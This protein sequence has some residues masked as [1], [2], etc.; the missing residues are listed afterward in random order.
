ML[1]KRRVVWVLLAVLLIAGAITALYFLLPFRQQPVSPPTHTLSQTPS[2]ALQTTGSGEA[3]PVSPLR[4]SAASP[5]FSLSAQQGLQHQGLVILSMQDGM[6]SHIF[7]F[8]PLYK[9][10]SRI[11]KG[12]WDDEYPAI[13]PDGSAIAMSSKRNGYW[14]IYILDIKR[15][16][17]KRVTDSPEYEGQLSWSPDGKFIAH[18][19]YIDNNLEIFIR[20]AEDINQP[21]VRLTD[22][23]GQDITPVW[24]PQGRQIA[25]CSN[26]TGEEE[27]W[28]ADL[29][30]TEDR[31]INISRDA[32]H[33]DT[34][35]VW[36]PDGRFLAWSAQ[37]TWETSLLIW[38]SQN[39][40]HPPRQVGSGEK[41]VWSPMGDI[42]LAQIPDPNQTLLAGYLVSD[43]SI[44]LPPTRL[45]GNVNG[46]DWKS[47]EIGNLM[48]DYPFDKDANTQAAPL[49]QPILSVNPVSSVGRFSVSKLNNIRAPYPFLHDAVDEAFASLKAETEI[50][51]GWNF[52]EN[53]ENAYLPLTE[54]PAPNMQKNWL[55]TGRAIEI[56]T[57]PL[58]A[59]WMY[60]AREDINAQVY[61]R[62]YIKT[63]YQDGSQG[64]PIK[65]SVWDMSAR[66]SGNP[67]FYENG[68]RPLPAPSGYYIDF[69]ALAR[70]YGWERLPA[71]SEWR[72][73]YP[74]ARFN[75]FVISDNLTWDQA[76]SELY[77]PELLW[78][79]T[80]VPTR[81][82]TPTQT[83]KDF[84]FESSTP[85]PLPSATSTPRP[86]WTAKP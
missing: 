62:L 66:Y 55:F 18:E 67:D 25:F 57:I 11:T 78:T 63:R 37:N 29:D 68:G 9:P 74:A 19:T 17:W 47:G 4:T 24:S 53:L 36:S 34:H 80:Y 69:T 59:G 6:F 43:G 33:S 49:W 46:I 85:T 8:H 52:L 82:R 86:T 27:I 42:L 56:N 10:L 50:L 51:L 3:P 54:P 30:K 73:Y 15:N 58:Q 41:P 12:E 5:T 26:R 72:A 81:T 64:K 22:H 83:P 21:P 40:N 32:T 75:Q 60:L 14:D 84:V 7:A 65:Q 1:S 45:P 28:L 71:L 38:D 79:A 13:K 48:A 61:W 2:I 31:L 39:P 35:P 76:M 23:P 44:Y 16:T 20:S 77:P 70:K